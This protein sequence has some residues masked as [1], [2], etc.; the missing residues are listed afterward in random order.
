MLTYN[1]EKYY[2]LKTIFDNSN[3]LYKKIFQK[4]KVHQNKYAQLQTML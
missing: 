2:Q 4:P 3:L 1:L